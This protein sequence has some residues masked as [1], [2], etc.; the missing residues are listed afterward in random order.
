MKK[1]FVA[2]AVIAIGAGAYWATQQ[3][4]TEPNNAMLAFVPA[5][6]PI[7]SAQFKPFPIKDYIDSIPDAQKQYPQE[8]QDLMQDEDD[9]RAK[10]FLGLFNRYIA[11]IKDGQTFVDTFGLP[12]SLTSYFYTLGALPVLK[13]DV[14]KP[15]VLWALLDGI[16]AE[17]GLSHQVR[18]IGG[19]N[20]RA[21]PLMDE[22][23][24]DKIDLVLAIDKGI[25]TVTLETSFS[26]P[27][28]LETA[29]GIKAIPN[30]LSESGIVEDIFAKHGFLKD[31]LSYINHQELVKAITTSDG[32]QL[33]KQLNH[34]YSITKED[35]FAELRSDV[36]RTELMG[37]AKNW[38]KTVMGYTEFEL[39]DKQMSMGFSTVIES[40]NQVILGALKQIRGFLPA[41]TQDINNSVFS[42]G[43]GVDVNE[44][45]PALTK[46]WNELLTPAYQCEPLMQMQSEMESQS[47]AMLGMFTGMANGVKGLSMS[48]INYELNEGAE[49]LELKDLDAIVTLSADDPITL[50]NMV[51][52]FAPEL[53]NIQLP[54][55]GSAVDLNSALQL[56]PY[57]GFS[58]NM[59]LKGNH[60]AIYSGDK[61]QQIADGLAKE[62]LSANGLLSVSAD[63]GKMFT[64]MMTL[65]EM[66][67]ESIPPEFADLKDYNM[68]VKVDIDVNTQGIVIDSF[69]QT[70]N[71][72]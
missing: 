41:Y 58:A 55:D 66:S 59:A 22:N 3:K 36:C 27:A 72:K 46:V 5:D 39:K 69:V 38:P 25:L 17:S 57:L 51:K 19:I 11:A 64:P 61:S 63:Y 30:P 10:F 33:A 53:A 45:V 60:L 67:G 16:D 65:L 18:A 54:T 32:N 13:L 35:P 1:A 2:A 40:N 24:E 15:D 8:L 9:P 62:T 6:T 4:E 70:H 23:E 12:D 29:L 44:F 56:P 68:K 34:F 37:I 52:P 49:Q 50:F 20:Y 31:G 48:L 71:S 28:L 43:L 47:P 26:D 42:F 21:Y 7:F 14:A